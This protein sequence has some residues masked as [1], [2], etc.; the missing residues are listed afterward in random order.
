MYYLVGLKEN[1]AHVHDSIDKVLLECIETKNDTQL[2]YMIEM[3]YEDIMYTFY[4][5]MKDWKMVRANR[6]CFEYPVGE[7]VVSATITPYGMMID[8]IGNSPM[9]RWFH[10]CFEYL[11]V[12]E[13]LV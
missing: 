7:E 2:Q 10:Y 13:I 8:A 12:M 3:K 11:L 6:N 1:F 5:Y 4:D 9:Y